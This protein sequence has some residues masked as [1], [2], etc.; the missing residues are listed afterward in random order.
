MSSNDLEKISK[1]ADG[2]IS[3][4]DNKS[5]RALA[6]KIAITMRRQNAM[7]INTQIEPS[8]KKFT[9]RTIYARKKQQRR[10]MFSK[11]KQRQYLKTKASS[12]YAQ[13]H[14]AF[15]VAQIAKTHHLGLSEKAKTI[16]KT[17]YYPKRE[18][19]GITAQDLNQIDMIIIQHL[20]N[21]KI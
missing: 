20:T 16:K 17:I 15:S 3:A 1:Y 2:V 14:F 9:P 4:L 7:R 10:K 18:L 13:I 6:Y 19:L 8:G 5:R 21:I 11:I 12:N